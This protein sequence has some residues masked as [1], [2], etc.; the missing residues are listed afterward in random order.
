[1]NIGPDRLDTPKDVPLLSPEQRKP[2]TPQEAAEQFEEVLL[3]QMLRT[4]TKGLFDNS[5]AGDDAPQWM[6]AYNDIQSDV[7]TAELS[8]QLSNS[9]KLGIAEMLLKQW[10]RNAAE[11]GGTPGDGATLIQQLDDPS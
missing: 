2:R 9:G 7:L 3:Q 8:K 4:M 6:G 11:D 1:M 10:E 5:L